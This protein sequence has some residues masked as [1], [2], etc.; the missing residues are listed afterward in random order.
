[1]RFST[2]QRNNVIISTAILAGIIIV[3]NIISHNAFHR[4]DLTEEKVF[5][6]SDSTRNLLG[7]LD[8]IVTV[9]AYFSRELPAELLVLRQEIKDTLDEYKNYS[10]GKLRVKFID[11]GDDEE[12]IQEVQGLGIPQ[13]Q[14]NIRS[15]DKYEVRNGYFGL[16]IIYGDK[17]E[18]IPLIQ[19]TRNLE[20][21][22]TA[23]IKKV[24][25]GEVGSIGFLSG[26]G[27]WG[28]DDELTIIKN[29]LQKQYQ[30]KSIDVSGDEFISDDIKTLVIAG[31]K[32]KFEEKELYIIDQF[33]MRGGNLFVGLDN[34]TV[35]GTL[36][37][38]NIET[39]LEKMLEYYGLRL[40][41]NLVLDSGSNES[42]SFSSG[43]AQFFTSYPFW[44]KVLK[45]GFNQESIISNKLEALVLPWVSTVEVLLGKVGDNEVLELVK[46]SAR[47][48]TATPP[49]DLDPQ[50][51]FAPVGEDG[52]QLVAVGVA[53]K[54]ESYFKG[55]EGPAFA[56]D[57]A[58]AGK[59]E[60]TDFIEST[61]KA[62]IVLVG[63]GDFMHDNFV[64]RFSDN[65]VFFENVVDYLSLGEELIE[66]R[67]RGVSDR[68]LKELSGASKGAVK[69]LNI[70][71]VT[72]LVILF[73]V[74]RFYGRRKKRFSD[75]L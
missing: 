3:V 50:Q 60:G 74:V 32:E 58:M 14:F 11:P 34:I 36:S 38:A 21:D 37:P 16:A 71:G 48:W 17:K 35:G 4:F 70:F 26:H 62:T 29:D 31:P 23:G 44:P 61:D 1:M 20:Y 59:L 53:G 75:G 42:V 45:Q 47:S 67:S 18:T 25:S 39:D 6:I 10:H 51:R 8:D 9:K 27:E 2:Q 52:S 56:P 64:S 72:G 73:G 41:K 46:T 69:F 28:I 5:S 30:V 49:Y 63:D 13:V 7:D 33:L 19:S 65:L 22:L 68:S 40:N 43:F 15:K 24:S 66:I 57:G 12:L 54:F 55:R